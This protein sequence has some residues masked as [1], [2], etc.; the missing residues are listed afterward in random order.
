MHKKSSLILYR[1][2]IEKWPCAWYYIDSSKKQ[3]NRRQKK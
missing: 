1:M 2:T 3:K